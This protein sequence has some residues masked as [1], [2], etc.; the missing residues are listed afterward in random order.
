MKV[1]NID[2]N[3]TIEEARALLKEEKNV[4]SAFKAMMEVLFLVMTLLINRLGLNSKNS[5]KSPATDRN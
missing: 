1:E 5:S 2:V 4:S 3:K